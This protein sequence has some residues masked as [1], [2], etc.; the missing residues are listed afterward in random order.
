[1][2][3]RF[4]ARASPLARPGQLGPQY[5]K[6]LAAG[7]A[8]FVKW[9]RLQP[10][11]PSIEDQFWKADLFITAFVRYGAQHRW[12]FYQVKHGVLALQLRFPRLRRSRIETWRP[13]GR[14]EARRPWRPRVP[15]S[16]ILLDVVFLT[17]LDL[18]VRSE[19]SR[20]KLLLQALAVLVRTGFS[21]LL[22]PGELLRLVTTDVEFVTPPGNNL[23]AVIAIADPKTRWVQGAGRSQFSTVRD[24]SV[25]SWLQHWVSSRERGRPLWPASR[26]AF[27][28]LL[29]DVL[30]VAGL[31]LAGFTPASLRAGG[32]T[33]ELLCGE[34]MENISFHG[35]WVS[36]GSL[37]S[38]LQEGC[39]HL[40]WASLP[41]ETRLK[42]ET[43]A[44][45]YRT[46]LNSPP[47]RWP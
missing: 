24:A 28:A 16:R 13:L 3:S 20:K 23:M 14:W 33:D 1:M 5:S 29:K 27:S 25:A 9:L 11:I 40:V 30:Q 31:G 15:I 32:A 21:A 34:S 2:H 41:A 19:D 42:C 26:S 17:A 35:R 38:Y 12:K 37:R 43:L 18:A 22:R 47:P 7:L 4:R 45:R 6:T 46:I 8:L 36:M 44:A 10:S 39:S